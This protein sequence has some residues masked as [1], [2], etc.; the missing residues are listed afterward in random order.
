MKKF[1]NMFFTTM[2]LV[3]LLICLVA[4]DSSVNYEDIGIVVDVPSEVANALFDTETQEEARELV[5]DQISDEKIE[6]FRND[7]K[8]S[9]CT[10]IFVLTGSNTSSYEEVMSEKPTLQKNQS[11]VSVLLTK[12]KEDFAGK[13][14]LIVQKNPST[15]KS[16]IIDMGFKAT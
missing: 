3:A 13:A 15:E 11:C 7:I 1:F 8:N 9:G 12:E 4:C 2:G 14:Y 10:G 6:A 16:Y 5:S